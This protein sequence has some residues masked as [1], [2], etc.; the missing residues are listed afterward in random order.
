MSDGNE[1]RGGDGEEEWWA[2]WKA[3]N[4]KWQKW[5]ANG[6]ILQEGSS[7]WGALNCPG[8]NGFLNVIKRTVADVRWVMK[9]MQNGPGNP[10]ESGLAIRNEGITAG[11]ETVSAPAPPMMQAPSTAAPAPPDPPP[12]APPPQ[13]AA[14]TASEAGKRSRANPSTESVRSMAAASR[15]AT[16]AGMRALLLAD[17]P[18]PTVVAMPA[19]KSDGPKE[20]L[21]DGPGGKGVLGGGPVNH[22]VEDI[23][24]FV[25]ASQA[26]DSVN[27]ENPQ[28][29]IS[30]GRSI[31]TWQTEVT[32]C[33][34]PL[35]LTKRLSVAA[36][37]WEGWG[38]QHT[39][40][41]EYV[42]DPHRVRGFVA[43]AVGEGFEPVDVGL[44]IFVSGVVVRVESD[45]GTCSVRSMSCDEHNILERIV[46]GVGNFV[47]GAV[48]LAKRGDRGVS[49]NDAAYDEVVAPR[50]T[51]AWE[52][53]GRILG[54]A[55]AESSG[56]EV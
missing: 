24:L 40:V 8:Q 30:K 35:S 33:E 54:W 2:W 16:R 31:S 50:G 13:V 1:R 11:A 6:R 26:R 21:G 53:C 7:T 20:R 22:R 38:G 44:G 48:Q 36:S 42:G 18:V 15:V 49:G 29:A 37:V 9:E 52:H 55:P 46:V 41:L 28:T 27:L 32:V 4:P 14:S 39:E 51:D 3:I 10:T 43:D 19:P 47:N 17:A 23:V 45:I 5:N 56:C 25:Q 12:G 34:A